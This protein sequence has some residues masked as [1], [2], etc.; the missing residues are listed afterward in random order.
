LGI[1]AWKSVIAFP[2]V[3]ALSGSVTPAAAQPT[4]TPET[5]AYTKGSLGWSVAGGGALPIGWLAADADRRLWL[6]TFEVGRIMT[7]VHGP[8][9]LSGH[10]ELLAQAMPVAS[11][12]VGEFWGVG[13]NPFFLRWNFTGTASVRPFGEL[14]AG[15]MLLDWRSSG[16]YQYTSNFNEQI[17]FGVRL[18]RP[19]GALVIGGRFMH[20]SHG[21]TSAPSPAI[22]TYSVYVGYSSH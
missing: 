16:P 15:F 11:Y 10:L 4:D 12:G 9:P 13:L 17:G 6:A 20:I 14:S 22:D 2:L 1:G 21:G 8:G 18:G 5:P 19:R 3:L 7:E